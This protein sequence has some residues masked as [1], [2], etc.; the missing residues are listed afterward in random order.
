MTV[1][2]RRQLF[3][4]S[5]SKVKAALATRIGP[6]SSLNEPRGAHGGNP[7]GLA[8]RSRIVVILTLKEDLH[9]ERIAIGNYAWLGNMT[10]RRR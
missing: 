10:R 6:G 1:P 8:P 3:A 2:I 5:R 9:A 7:E 4:D